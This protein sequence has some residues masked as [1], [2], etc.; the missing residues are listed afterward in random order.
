MRQFR[1]REEICV[2]ADAGHPCLG[3]DGLIEGFLIDEDEL[4]FVV[5]QARVA[6]AHIAVFVFG[7]G[8]L[9]LG[10]AREGE[11]DEEG[12]ERRSDQDASAVS[13]RRPIFVGGDKLHAV[14]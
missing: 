10:S 2:A 4:T 9:G 3:V 8:R 5:F 1:R 14:F 6:V 13:G 7:E 12:H 11:G